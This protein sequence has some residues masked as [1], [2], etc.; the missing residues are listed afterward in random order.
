MILKKINQLL[1][2]ALGTKVMMWA[3]PDSKRFIKG[4]VITAY[5]PQCTSGL[6]LNQRKPNMKIWCPN[7][8]KMVHGPNYT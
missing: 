4:I 2:L 8:P 7:D 5:G 1:V 6:S 3:V